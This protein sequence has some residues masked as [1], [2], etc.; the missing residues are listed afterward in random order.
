MKKIL[1]I[2]LLLIVSL[3]KSQDTTKIYH[4]EIGFNTVSLIKQLISNSPSSTLDQLPYLIFYNYSVNR[5]FG[6]RVGLGGNI[7]K[8]STPIDGQVDPRV[9][10]TSNINA[11]V[12]FFANYAHYNRVTLN[13]FA[14]Y[15]Y[16]GGKLTSSN[17]FTVQEFPDPVSTQKVESSVK[18]SGMGFQV[19]TGIKYNVYK[20]L[21]LYIELPI[22]FLKSKTTAQDEIYKNGFLTQFTTSSSKSTDLKI[23]VPTTLYLVLRF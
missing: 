2:T 10:N 6:V 5:T 23:T 17:T 22:S 18:S 14:D 7:S 1:T 15:L 21:S 20:N 13:A 19:G 16:G 9:T 4:N 3:S 11:R 12:G 8:I